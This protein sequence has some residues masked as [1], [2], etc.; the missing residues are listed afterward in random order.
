MNQKAQY[1]LLV[2]VSCALILALGA[3]VGA[4]SSASLQGRKR[5]AAAESLPNFD[6]EALLLSA[7]L[8]LLAG[9]LYWAFGRKRKAAFNEPL[10]HAAP[11]R[12][13]LHT[14]SKPQHT[15]KP[16]KRKTGQHQ[17]GR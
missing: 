17:N 2:L 11:S 16:P 4:R 6:G 14:T 8:I 1:R 12:N 9:L 7:M 5:S 13:A 15:R 3:L 10:W